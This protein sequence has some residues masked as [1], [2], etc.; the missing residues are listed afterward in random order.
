MNKMQM[1]YSGK[2][3][4]IYETDNPELLIMEYR[5]DTSAF[6][7]V[8]TSALANKGKVNN[9][10]NAHIMT[11]LAKQGVP[12]HFEQLLSDSES[13]VKRLQMI[14]IECVIRNVTAGSIC[15][16]LGLDKG[17]ELEQ[18]IFEFFYKDDEL[19]DPMINDYHILALGWASEQAIETMKT[20][21]FRVNDIL[22]QV[23]HDAG[24]VL[25]DYKLE[26]GIHDGQV[27]LGDEFTPDGCRLWDVDTK[28]SLDKDRFRQDLGDVVESYQIAAKR[29]NIVVPT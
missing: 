20:L 19:G 25:V 3:K 9:Y 8:K 23:F 12:T 24:M 27:Y 7:G 4:S 10:F 2:A 11:L 16:R 5:D 26:F 18:P 21:T 13:L 14:P 22:K 1:L 6:N 28:E 17:L 29:L 15:K